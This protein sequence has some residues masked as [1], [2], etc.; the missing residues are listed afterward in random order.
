MKRRLLFALAGL[1]I[2]LTMPA[3]AQLKESAPSEQDRQQI[4]AQEARYAEAA[5][6]HDAAAIAALFTEDGVFVSPDGI[7]SGRPAIRP[8]WLVPT[9]PTRPRP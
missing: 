4:D 8:T 1:A 5:N 7:L 3:L 2:G 6:R 9:P